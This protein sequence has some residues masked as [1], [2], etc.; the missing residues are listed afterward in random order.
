LL[1]VDFLA[2]PA[3]PCK[4]DAW[5]CS[6]DLGIGETA[7]AVHLFLVFLS[8]SCYLVTYPA[9]VSMDE[10]GFT[11]EKGFICLALASL[12]DSTAWHVLV[13]PLCAV[14]V[15]CMHKAW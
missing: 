10:L 7:L 8:C 14:C 4:L 1:L 9:A 5:L 2:C 12:V 15:C 6:G 3:P 13:T 11:V